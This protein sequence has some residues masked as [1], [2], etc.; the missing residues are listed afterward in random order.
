MQIKTSIV[1]RGINE[2]ENTKIIQP[3]KCQQ[4]QAAMPEDIIY[5]I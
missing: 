3:I 2:S 1:C 4:K 5:I